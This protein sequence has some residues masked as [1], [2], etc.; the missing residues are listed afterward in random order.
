M[1]YYPGKYYQVCDICGS[2]GYNTEMVKTWNGLVVHRDTCFDG[3]RDPLDK[4]PPLRPE[5]QTVP[6]PRPPTTLWVA[7]YI[8]TESQEHILMENGDN[9]SEEFMS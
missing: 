7:K 1:V 9:L 3:P 5:R 2:K 8:D 6:D 4:P